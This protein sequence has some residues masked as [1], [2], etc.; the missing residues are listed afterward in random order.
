MIRGVPCWDYTD[1]FNSQARSTN[2]Q[3]TP[4]IPHRPFPGRRHQSA[5]C[6]SLDLE[7]AD[8]ISEPTSGR[9]GPSTSVPSMPRHPGSPFLAE[10]CTIGIAMILS[11]KFLEIVNEKT[12]PKNWPEESI[13][14][15]KPSKQEPLVCLS[16]CR[17]TLFRAPSRLAPQI[18]HFHNLHLCR[19]GD[20]NVASIPGEEVCGKGPPKCREA[21][22]HLRCSAAG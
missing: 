15:T 19:S 11:A 14:N 18:Q 2:P 12:Y 7:L 8:S 17:K 9:Q 6:E 20:W 22:M 13:G 4:R 16:E 21:G 5:Q 1:A 3:E 10:D